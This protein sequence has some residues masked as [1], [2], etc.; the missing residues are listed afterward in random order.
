MMKKRN[1]W[2]NSLSILTVA[3]VTWVNPA[4]ANEVSPTTTTDYFNGESSIEIYVPPPEK[5]STGIC[6]TLLEPAIN[7]IIGKY[8]NNWGILVESLADGTV[9]YSHNSDKF[10]IP[11]SNT[12]L[13]TTAAALQKLGLSAAIG[14]KS[15]KDWITTTNLFSNNYYADTLLRRLGGPSVAKAALSQLGIDPNTYRL[16][17]GSGLSRNN[18]ATPRAIISI[19]RAMYYSPEKE[20]FYASLP[21]AGVSGTLRNRMRQTPAQGAVFAKT[22]TLSGVRALSGYMNHPQYGMLAF[23]I[24]ANYPYESSYIVNSI[25]KIVLQLSMLTP[26]D[27]P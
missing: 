4:I 7:A 11:A 27:T 21:V 25:D 3:T 18:A 10:F 17:D 26:C 20:A 1:Y 9:I 2:L 19:L 24:V 5:P 8:S 6:S 13:F 14:N 22:G 12:K 23:S 15:L 16:A